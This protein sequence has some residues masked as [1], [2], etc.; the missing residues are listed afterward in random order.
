MR[1]VCTL[2]GILLLLAKDP[3]ILLLTW[4][5]TSPVMSNLMA[6]PSLNPF[7]GSIRLVYY[8]GFAHAGASLRE[9]FDYDRIVLILVF[10][11]TTRSSRPKQ[12]VG[13]S[14]QFEIAF[15]LLLGAVCFSV[16]FSLNPVNATRKAVDTFGLCYISYLL[17]KYLLSDARNWQR[18]VTAIVGLGCLLMLTGVIERRLYGGAHDADY[19][20]TGPFRYWETFGMAVAQI[21]YVFWFRLTTAKVPR[22]VLKRT[23]YS[24]LLLVGAWCIFR[25]QTRTVMVAML[26]GTVAVALAGARSVISPKA[27]RRTL[28]VVGL[29][30]VIIWLDPAII[31]DRRFYRMRVKNQETA[32]S[33]AETY[34][35]A[36]RMFARN[37]ITG[38]G[39]KNFSFVMGDYISDDEVEY[40]KPGSSSLHCSYLVV[41]AECGLI[42]LIPLAFVV[43]YSYRNCRFCLRATSERTDKA[44]A[45]AMIGMT[46]TYYMS[47]T[48]FD[49]FFDPTMQNKLYYM[50]LGMTIGRLHNLTPA[51][52]RT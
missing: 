39:L 5:V 38:V 27:M 13:L 11:A 7:F 20:I 37:P 12:N 1:I 6:R 43:V 8:P 30:A 14:R 51:V 29:I 46:V 3:V 28:A 45:V 16:F 2:L 35:A 52:S 34:L 47:A 23:L 15:A 31:T 18:F 10:L 9:F 50:C 40:S 17:G 44:W 26:L 21:M 22:L 32:N 49:P 48:A 25:T 42:G 36:S 19:R 4:V 41:A 33:R 24:F